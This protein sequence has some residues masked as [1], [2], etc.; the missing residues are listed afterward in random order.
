MYVQTP[1]ISVL[2]RVP[3]LPPGKCGLVP[4]DVLS[5]L[6]DG[7]SKS[8]LPAQDAADNDT[9]NTYAEKIDTF[10]YR[11][12]NTNRAAA[13]STPADAIPSES[14]DASTDRGKSALDADTRSSNA[15]KSA[16]DNDSNICNTD[17]SALIQHVRAR[18][19][20]LGRKRSELTFRK[21]DCFELLHMTS[22]EW[23]KV[24]NSVGQIGYVPA[25]YV[26]NVAPLEM[27]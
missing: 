23:W 18:Y 8:T 21:G 14:T 20:Y 1:S 7:G 4:H 15:D 11:A 25:N 24:C 19:A 3:C 6:S 12:V 22:T 27:V 13:Q 16:M 17:K 10:P 2:H 26:T 5:G 9:F